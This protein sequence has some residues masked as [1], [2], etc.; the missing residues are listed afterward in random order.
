[1][2]AS[3]WFRNFTAMDY[4]YI[5]ENG[6]IHGNSL[7]VSALVTGNITNE[8]SVVIDFSKGK[9]MMKD[10]I[11]NLENGLD[12]KL[13]IFKDSNCKVEIDN[14]NIFTLSTPFIF[15]SVPSNSIHKCKCCK[16][17]L[18]QYMSNLLTSKMNEA[19]FDITIKIELSKDGFDKFGSYFSYIHGLKNS[20]SLGCTNNSHGHRSFVEV[21]GDLALQDEIANYLND[22]IMIYKDNVKETNYEHIIITYECIRGKYSSIY[23]KPHNWIIY[24]TET[25]IEYMIKHIAEVFKYKLKGKT[26]RISEGLQKGAELV[27]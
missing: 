6:L 19:G 13:L 24:D 26:L 23:Y 10:I 11:D 5:N 2:N 9:K 20:S 8:E 12:H 4:G 16:D 14:C 15:L 18:N 22:K 1:M 3:I 27:C 21:Y 7:H 25:T 17:E